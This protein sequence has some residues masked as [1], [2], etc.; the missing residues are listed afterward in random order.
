MAKA[1]VIGA[2]IAH[3]R[4]PLIHGH[5]L[6]TLGI[7]GS[8]EAVHVE[9]DDLPAFIRHNDFDGGNVTLPH[10]EQIKPLLDR[11]TTTAQRVGAVNTV[12]REG[13]RL[14][15]DNT[16]G[17]GFIANLDATEPGWRDAPG[18]ALVLGAGG[19]A[20][21][22]VDALARAGFAITIANRT[23]ARAEALAME[24]AENAMITSLLQAPLERADLVVNTTSI[25]MDGSMLP[26][27]IKA[28]RPDA[29]V[30]DIVYTPLETP[31]LKAA[32]TRGCRTVDGLGMLL[33]Q[34][35]PGFE[36][37]FGERPEVTAELRDIILAD[38]G[39]S[40]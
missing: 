10:K 5:W 22:V 33:H 8:Y 17:A 2:P 24:L 25:G 31:L 35:V 30:T 36:R 9:P 1:F 38:L 15:G 6:K 23:M 29:L 27:D 3:S 4:S 7:E 34:A 40:A 20:R 26:F 16:D 28:L 19:A 32:R 37:W 39:A 11:L 12:W 13:D 21:A 14:V 18:N